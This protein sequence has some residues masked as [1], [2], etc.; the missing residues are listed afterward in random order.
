MAIEIAPVKKENFNKENIV[1]LF[2]I[3]ILAASFGL[4]F[5]FS[6]VVL[7]G[8]ENETISLNSQLSSM[9]QE[10]IKIKEAELVEAGIYI[11]DFKILLENNPKASNFFS[12]FQEWAHP[13]IVY[14]GFNFDAAGKVSMSGTTS[15]FQNVMQQIALLDQEGSVKSY[16]ISNVGMSETGGVTFNLNLDIEPEVLK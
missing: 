8:K 2:S 10:D 6:K 1:L 7:V 5:Y 14:S 9:G 3:L 4:Y 12:A 16:E 11:S 15:G 13:K